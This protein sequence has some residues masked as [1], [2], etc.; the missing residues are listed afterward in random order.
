MGKDKRTYKKVKEITEPI[1]NLAAYNTSRNYVVGRRNSKRA[2][3]S[4]LAITNFLHNL[5]ETSK[6]EIM[7][8][9]KRRQ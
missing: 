3:S 9:R 7:E 6:E 5:P 2:S 1:F 8:R 4:V